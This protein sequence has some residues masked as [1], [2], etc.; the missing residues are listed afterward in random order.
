MDV[1]YLWP[2]WPLVVVL[3]ALMFVADEAG[4]RIGARR[5]QAVAES[6]RS[7]SNGLKASVFGLVA[8]LLGFSFS[9]TAA[10][11]DHRRKVVL[12]EANAISTCHLRAGLLDEP[13][14]GRIRETMRRYLDVRLDYFDRGTDPEVVRQTSLEMDRLLAELWA[15]VE[16]AAWKD[17]Q[18]VRVS[19]IVPAANEMIDLNRTRAWAVRNHLPGLVLAML[20]VGVLVSSLLIGHSCGQTGRRYVWLWGSFNVLFALVLFVILDFDR[21]RRGLIQVDHAPL[22]ELKATIAGRPG[23]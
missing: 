10:R 18:K 12:D 14:R 19:Q 17:R 5:H 6:V 21:P 16:M 3:L 4:F 13:E 8:L 2:A 15:A 1:I 22:I 7:V 11:H 9:N 23:E 20:F